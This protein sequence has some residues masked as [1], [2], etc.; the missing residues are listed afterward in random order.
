MYSSGGIQATTRR[1][2]LLTTSI[3]LD[4][5]EELQLKDKY[6]VHNMDIN[7]YIDHTPQYLS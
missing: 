5:V 7:I 2:D 4:I 3:D 6:I 1:T